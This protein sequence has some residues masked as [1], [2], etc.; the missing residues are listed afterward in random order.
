MSTQKKSLFQAL[1]SLADEYR[2]EEK[3]AGARIVAAVT[4]KADGPTPSDPGS[5]HPSASVDNGCQTVSTGAHAAENSADIKE[6]QGPASVESTSEAK[7]G[8]DKDR[9]LNL[10]MQASLVG[11][12]PKTEDNYKSDKDDP[13]TSSP[14]KV[15]DGKKYASCTFKEAASKAAELGNAILADLFNGFDAKSAPAT[16]TAAAVAAAAT[17][18]PAPLAQGYEL[19][20]MLGLSKEAAEA[21]VSESAEATIRDALL[22]AQLVGEYFKSASDEAAEGEDHSSPAGKPED[23]GSGAGEGEGSG[24]ASTASGGGAPGGDAGGASADPMAGLG[25]GG[26][27]PGAG[28]GGAPGGMSQE[29]ALQELVM[30][31]QELGITPE[32]LEQASAGAMGGAP[33]GGGGMPPGGGAD[34]AMGGGDPLAM[35]AA[36]GGMPPGGAGGGMPPGGDAGGMPSGVKLAHA[37]RKFMRSGKFE[38][39]AAAS[40]QARELRNRMK[41]HLLEITS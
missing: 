19:A 12:D 13:G 3:E 36:G 25:G 17:A 29:Q 8:D 33:G 27:P 32:M 37:A 23:G 34:P 20:G 38:F 30:A 15:D 18:A 2:R 24:D 9:S 26:P 1:N 7:P 28:A 6:Q 41:Q 11:D 40:K 21:H 16:K 10:G 22:E 35:G 4:K 31:M 39:K 14:A 5:A